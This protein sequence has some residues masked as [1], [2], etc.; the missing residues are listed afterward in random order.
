MIHFF[1]RIRQKLLANK[2][3]KKYILYAIGEIALVMIG[4][5]LALQVNNWNNK[6]VNNQIES[7]VLKQIHNDFLENKIS[8]ESVTSGRRNNLNNCLKIMDMFPINPDEVNLDSLSFLIKTAAYRGTF[9]PAN[10]AINT[11]SNTS[12]FNIIKNEKLR[13]LLIQWKDLVEDYLE[14]EKIA[15]YHLVNQWD[16]YFNKRLI[17]RYSDTVQTQDIF[18]ERIDL[19][20]LKS[21]EFQNLVIRRMHNLQRSFNPREEITEY[22]LIKKSIDEIIDLTK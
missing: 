15:D 9:N 5:L 17:Q 18:D 2:Q 22:E 14:D 11:L 8:F 19:S 4:I 16:P 21:I 10:G 3:M 13:D 12:S 6:R 1:R 7:K 20:F